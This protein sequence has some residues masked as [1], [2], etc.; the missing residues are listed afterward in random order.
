MKKGSR[1]REDATVRCRSETYRASPGRRR[2]RING[3]RRLR[4]CAS[5]ITGWK[6]SKVDTTHRSA[7]FEFGKNWESYA[8]LID[9][10][11]LAAA[12]SATRVLCGDLAG[13]AF[14]DIGSGSGLFSK[15]ALRLGARRVVAVDLDENS[16]A[17]TRGVLASEAG[18]WTVLQASVFDLAKMGLGSF[19]VVYSWG[20]L[21]HTGDLWRAIECAAGM[22]APGGRFAF[23]L[24]ER[25]PLCGLW[26]REKR[27]YSKAHPRVQK[28][29]R[30][31]Y[32]VP[33]A[34]ASVA[35]GR[36]PFRRRRRGMDTM[37][38]IHDWLGGYP[39]QPT[40]AGEVD[41]ALTALGF[42]REYHKPVKVHLAGLFGTGCSEYVY[43]R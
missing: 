1:S 14:L 9:D 31:A 27:F 22:V 19:D 7:H 15:A 29:M 36:N 30:A 34:A 41:R 2:Y 11:R 32:L 20:V 39:Y 33:Y 40:D 6:V 35:A 18:D 38:D 37:H 28:L 13:K 24:Y 12:M 8:S 4:N 5:G 10:D 3:E 17:A 42:V 16:I 26:E 43:T 23:S 25:T 21:H